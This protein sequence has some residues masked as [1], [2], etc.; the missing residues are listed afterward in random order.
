MPDFKL[1]S[2]LNKIIKIKTSMYTDSMQGKINLL[3]M[4]WVGVFFLTLIL[5][6]WKT[7]PNLK[8]WSENLAASRSNSKKLGSLLNPSLSPPFRPVSVVPTIIV[9][10][11]PIKLLFTGDLM[12]DR[13]IRMAAEKSGNDFIFAPIADLL[14][15]HQL[16]IT[17]LEGP[18]TK[19][20][21]KSLG[22]AVGSPANYIFTFDPSLAETLSQHQ[23]SLVNLGNNHILNFGEAGLT[24]TLENLASAQ[25]SYFGQISPNQDQTKIAISKTLTLEDQTIAFVNYNQFSP[26]PAAQTALAEIK[27]LRPKVDW[28]IVYAHWDREYETTALP[29]TTK[30]AH[31][32]VAAGADLIIGSHPHVIQNHEIY[33]GKEIYYSLGNFVFDQYFE[34][35]VQR[36]LAVSVQLESKPK[37]ITTQSIYLKLQKNSQTSVE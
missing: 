34:P 30:L 12:F 19:A 15:N 21:S 31:D 26:G 27:A 24:E 18:V 20:N 36:G 3:W 29:V 22:S 23:I 32:F 14:K 28:L 25:V 9:T 35:N 33:Q 6:I 10:P 1:K 4:A 5:I 11:P 13:H 16:V 37:K 17:N 2:N 8:N 7:S